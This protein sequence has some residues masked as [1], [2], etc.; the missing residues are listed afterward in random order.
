MTLPMSTSGEQ[1]LWSSVND[2]LTTNVPAA[3]T[4]AFTY[5]FDEALDPAKF[6]QVNVSQFNSF[7]PGDTAL[8]G[9]IFTNNPTGRIQ[10]KVNRAILAIDIRDD[11]SVHNNALQTVRQLRDAFEYALINAGVFSEADNAVLFP[12][13]VVKDSGGSTTNTF[14]RVMTES[15]NAIIKN[16][17]SPKPPETQIV[18]Y[19]LLFKMEW[20]ELL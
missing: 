2:W 12:P 8:G 17:Y 1:E 11:G 19:Q 20:Y 9:V 4:P 14:A 16:F 5:F 15:D 13:I 7:E 10:G 18:R 3:G 6:P